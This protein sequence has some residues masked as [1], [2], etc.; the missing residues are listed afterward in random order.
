MKL[1]AKMQAAAQQ[2]KENIGTA[3][4]GRHGARAGRESEGINGKVVEEGGKPGKGAK[5]QPQAK[6][7]GRKGKQAN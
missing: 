2:D 4:N 7:K 5:K 1:S 3:S 6:G